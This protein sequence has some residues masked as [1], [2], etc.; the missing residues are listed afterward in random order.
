MVA[1]SQIE[2]IASAKLGRAVTVGGVDF[3]PWS[4]ELTLNDLSIAKNGS[5]VPQLS[6]KR[7]YIDAELES[8]LYLA[9]VVDAVAVDALSVSLTHLGGAC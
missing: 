7:F 2:K 5:T 9:P 4:L 3:K 8:L 1:K 6:I